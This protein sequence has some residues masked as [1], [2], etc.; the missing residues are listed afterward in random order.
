MKLR[1]DYEKDLISQ[2]L[3]ARIEKSDLPKEELKEIPEVKDKVET[4]QMSPEVASVQKETEQ[5]QEA[6]VKVPSSSELPQV[7]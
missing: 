5:A 3:T 6:T 4:E 1:D 7:E 2:P